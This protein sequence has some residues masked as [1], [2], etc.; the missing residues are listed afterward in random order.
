MICFRN[1]SALCKRISKSKID[2]YA[3]K[4]RTYRHM[5]TKNRAYARLTFKLLLFYKINF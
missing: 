2:K 3:Y 5:I 1:K 4:R